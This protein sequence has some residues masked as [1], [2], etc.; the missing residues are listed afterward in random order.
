MT[1]YP[2][3]QYDDDEYY[4]QSQQPLPKIDAGMNKYGAHS[5]RGKQARLHVEGKQ[6]SGKNTLKVILIVFAVLAL[7]AAGI[8]VAVEVKRCTTEVEQIGTAKENVT[9]SIPSGYGSGDIAM[10]LRDNGIIDST[11]TFIK[12]VKAEGAEGSLKAGKY[13][14]VPGM[15]Y[16]EVVRTLVKGPVV[17]GV[18]I[19]F[20][21][22]L[23]VRQTAQRVQDALGIPVEDFLAQAHA[24]FYDEE[25][26]FLAG[27]YNDSLEGFLFPKTYIFEEDAT[28]DTVIRTLLKQFATE[29]AE[30]DMTSAVQG[31]VALTPYEVVVMASLVERE[32]AAAEE[33]PVVAS[34]M[35]NR[36]NSGWALQIDATIAYALGKAGLLTIEDT[37]VDSPYN[38]YQNLG[39]CP[40]PICSPSLDSIVAVL[41][42]AITP[43]YFYVASPDLDGTHVFCVDINEFEV[44]KSRY[45]AAMGII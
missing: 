2:N 14:F 10:L 24:S 38:T 32:T 44:A 25:Y 13:T 5:A 35:F 26:T 9:I 21:E 23:T 40:G 7:V 18:T 34:V 8:F 20:P 15:T 42:V 17:V 28:A 29:T 6:K 1:A 33:R 12:T 30:L 27:A 36:L 22:G 43:Y 37:Y 19:T 31:N 39:L 3:N 41:N 4:Y 45:N 11:T 16:Q